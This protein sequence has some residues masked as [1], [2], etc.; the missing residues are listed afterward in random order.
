MT[1]QCGQAE[2][3]RLTTGLGAQSSFAV[4]E[5]EERDQA[6]VLPA[7]CGPAARGI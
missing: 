1:V 6:A 7:A 2:G 4:L 3:L 5:E